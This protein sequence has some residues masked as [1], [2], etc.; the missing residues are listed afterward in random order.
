M[1]VVYFSIIPTFEPSRYYKCWIVCFY[2][3]SKAV[4]GFIFF[5]SEVL[6]QDAR[7]RM[8]NLVQDHYLHL[9]QDELL[10]SHKV[11][12]EQHR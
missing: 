5:I 12:T 4:K 9:V 1:G 8:Q 10:Y 7:K 3:K 6:V 2:Y 11:D